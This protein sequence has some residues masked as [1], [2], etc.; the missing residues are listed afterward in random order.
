MVNMKNFIRNFKVQGRVHLQQHY[1]HINLMK[2][3]KFVDKLKRGNQTYHNL[4][5]S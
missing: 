5:S 4:L 2:I 3:C 1:V